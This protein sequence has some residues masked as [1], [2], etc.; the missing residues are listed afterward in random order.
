MRDRRARQAVASH[1]HLLFFHIYLSRYVKYPTAD[2]QRQLFKLTED[3]GI[4]H[5]AIV[6]FRG[7]A[8]TTIMT[9]SYPLWS[10]LGVKQR[11]FVLLLSQT[12]NQ[13]RQMLVNLKREIEDNDI[14][15]ND[16]GALERHTDE[17]GRE[18]LVIK[19]YGARIMAASTETSIRGI[20]FGEH[21]PDL[22]ICD[23]VEDLQSTGTYE[24]RSKTYNWLMGDVIPAGDTDTQVIVIG[25]LL[26]QDS[27]LMRL[28][29]DMEND[30][31]DGAFLAFPLVDDDNKPLWPG[32]FTDQDS[33]AALRKTVPSLPAWER[34]YMLNIVPDLDQIVFPEWIQ[35]YDK[36]PQ[37]TDYRSAMA[38]DL[39]IGLKRTNDYTAILSARIY[40]RR[41][42][43][44]IF[45]LPNII[46][47]RMPFPE[48]RM[49]IKMVADTIGHPTIYIED[50][51]YQRSIIQQLKQDGYKVEGAKVFG[52]D[53]R[54]RL[55]TVTHLLQNG[56]VHFPSKGAEELIR[57]LVG[58]GIERH[59]DLAD[60]L[61][62]LLHKA[63]EHNR[64]QVRVFAHKPAPFA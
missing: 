61:S 63:L 42:N 33:I 41:D 52:Q 39:A 32:K 25:N 48:Q 62:I 27:L 24:G 29:D 38:V 36:L 50:V 56:Q 47:K 49:M 9:L 23:D 54:S 15:R 34:E 11:K 28:K 37:D 51:A 45:I 59:D 8:K 53:K 21:R 26:H 14:L 2:F 40:G 43:M 20:R 10:I 5:A 1:N 35:R 60:A 55:E 57:Q 22:I 12:Q 6:A 4:K 46:N 30:N 17:W 7:S 18:S 19:K 13:A 16:F 58:F 3:P 64:R 31:L 44:H